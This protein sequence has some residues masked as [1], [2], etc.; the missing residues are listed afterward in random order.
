MNS[1]LVEKMVLTSVI[2][3]G[4]PLPVWTIH[5]LSHLIYLKI[6]SG[7]WDKIWDMG[8]HLLKK[9]VK[10]NFEGLDLSRKPSCNKSTVPKGLEIWDS[11]FCTYANQDKTDL[12]LCHIII[13]VTNPT[14]KGIM[15]F[16]CQIINLGWWHYACL[17]R[18]SACFPPFCLNSFKKHALRGDFGATFKG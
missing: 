17:L 3:L 4:H 11:I 9:M 1:Q 2:V 14:G 12:R 18:F 13:P 10:S 7:T 8:I 5:P 16:V 15:M 6:G